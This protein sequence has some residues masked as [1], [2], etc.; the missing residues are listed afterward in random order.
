MLTYLLVTVDQHEANNVVEKI[1]AID[2]DVVEKVQKKI[3]KVY[4]VYGEY[5]ILVKIKSHDEA[6][7]NTVLQKIRSIHGVEFVKTFVVAHKTNATDK[8]PNKKV[9]YEK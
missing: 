3:N 9:I 6:D 4:I 1:K 2:H 5:D 7:A 8:L